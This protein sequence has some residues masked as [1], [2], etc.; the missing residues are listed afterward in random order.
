LKF[1]R[2]NFGADKE[3]GIQVYALAQHQLTEELQL[4]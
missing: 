3:Y 1:L 2:T 4:I